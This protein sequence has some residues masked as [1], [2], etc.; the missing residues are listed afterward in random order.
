MIHRPGFKKRI[1][2]LKEGGEGRVFPGV[3]WELPIPHPDGSVL[4]RVDKRNYS[5]RQR[6]LDYEGKAV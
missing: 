1:R 2:G 5:L 3:S 6:T 4:G